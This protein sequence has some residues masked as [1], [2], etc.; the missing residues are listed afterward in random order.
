M[1]P[2]P[3]LHWFLLLGLRDTAGATEPI[4]VCC[5]LRAIDAILFFTNSRWA[6]SYFDPGRFC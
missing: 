5:L 3:F 4:V 6:V 2:T 1:V